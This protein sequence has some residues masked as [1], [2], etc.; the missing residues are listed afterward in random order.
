MSIERDPLMF[1]AYDGIDDEVICPRCRNPMSLT[2]LTQL[3]NP[4]YEC[5]TFM[6]RQCEYEAMRCAGEDQQPIR[7]DQGVLV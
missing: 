6:C 3:C 1:Y 2:R 5:Q 7:F 4:G